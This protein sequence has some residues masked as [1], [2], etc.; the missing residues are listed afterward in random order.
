MESVNHEKERS[1]QQG[2][3]D[4]GRDSERLI[5]RKLNAATGLT[6]KAGLKIPS[7]DLRHYFCA[8]NFRALIIMPRNGGWV[9]DILLRKS[10]PEN[11][12]DIIGT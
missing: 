2:S 6:K 3:T 7:D 9:A 12:G 5:L 4:Q 8:A 10:S 1:L 11:D